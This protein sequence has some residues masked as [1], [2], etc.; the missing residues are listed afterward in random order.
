[1]ATDATRPA[2][3][4]AAELLRAVNEQLVV[5]H[6]ELDSIR[7]V[8]HVQLFSSPAGPAEPTTM[9]VIMNGGQVDRSPCGTGTTAKVATLLSK[10]Q[11]EPGRPFV[12][13]SMT[14]ASYEGRAV[15][16][17][18]VGSLPSCRVAITGSA[19]LTADSTIYLDRDDVL[20][21]GFQL[22]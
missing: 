17:G 2:T 16:R 8:T 3:D 5:Q 14:G 19:Y 7:G 9:M 18:Q 4:F 11:L 21:G 20:A 6:P 12:H 22:G 15:E 10:G 13:T 1:M